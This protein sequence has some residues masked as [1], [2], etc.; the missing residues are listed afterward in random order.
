M[1]EKQCRGAGRG[2]ARRR[3]FMQTV[4]A[5]PTWKAFLALRAVSREAYLIMPLDDENKNGILYCDQ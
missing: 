4:K 1:T 5:S 3:F 2:S